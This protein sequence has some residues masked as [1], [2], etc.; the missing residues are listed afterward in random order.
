[1]VIAFSHYNDGWGAYFDQIANHAGDTKYPV[2]HKKRMDLLSLSGMANHISLRAMYLTI[3]KQECCNH[4][5]VA[6]QIHPRESN[7]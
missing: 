4:I 2:I 1:M 6:V 5:N 3:V 7:I